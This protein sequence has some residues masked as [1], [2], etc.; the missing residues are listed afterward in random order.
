MAGQDQSS[1]DETRHLADGR[2]GSPSAG[3][4]P[5]RWP[6]PAEKHRAYRQRQREGQR[7]LA[8]LL[9]AVRDASLEGRELQKAAV[10]GDDLES[11]QALIRHYQARHWCRPRKED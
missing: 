3:G 2:G 9:T 7:L 8:E 4:R 5:R 6:T 1:R 10:D 11:L